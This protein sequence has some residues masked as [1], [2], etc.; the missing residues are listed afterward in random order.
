[1]LGKQGTG[2]STGNLA[3]LSQ[4]RG[5][6]PMEYTYSMP[7]GHPREGPWPLAY[8]SPWL[9]SVVA[10]KGVRSIEGSISHSLAV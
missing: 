6:E 2:M 4:E 3:G 9:L 5:S 1:M 10:R 7:V 8:W